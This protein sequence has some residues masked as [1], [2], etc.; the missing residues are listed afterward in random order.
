MFLLVAHRLVT[1]TSTMCM[2]SVSVEVLLRL[3]V[4][5]NWKQKEMNYLHGQNLAQTRYKRLAQSFIIVYIT[6]LKLEPRVQ[7]RASI[8]TPPQLGSTNLKWSRPYMWCL[9]PSTGASAA[10]KSTTRR[11]GLICR[12]TLTLRSSNTS[13]YSFTMATGW[14]TYNSPF[15][16][17]WPLNLSI[18]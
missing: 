13:E 2:A 9:S 11:R 5:L 7:M 12:E 18:H 16:F 10:I 3:R 6:V 1:S 8:H 17:H 14:E 15:P 4:K